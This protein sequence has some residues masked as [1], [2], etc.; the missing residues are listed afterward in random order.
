MLEI[1]KVVLTCLTQSQPRVGVQKFQYD[2]A[3]DNTLTLVILSVNRK[4][5]FGSFLHSV[6]SYDRALFDVT[7]LDATTPVRIANLL[8]GTQQA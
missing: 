8:K 2:P 6:D 7:K 5:N 1:K 3:R 4:H